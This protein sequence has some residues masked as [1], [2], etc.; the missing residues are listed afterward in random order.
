[1]ETMSPYMQLWLI[2]SILLY[3]V[4]SQRIAVIGG[5]ISGTFVTRYLTE[6]DTGCAFESITLFDPLPLGEVVTENSSGKDDSWQ[7]SR[8]STLQFND[9]R[10]IELGASIMTDKFVLIKEMAA[11]GNLTLQ[12]PF[13]TGLDEPG[14]RDGMLIYNGKGDFALNNANT[15]S[16]SQMISLFWRYNLDLFRLNRAMK[17]AMAKFSDLEALIASPRH[18]FRS[19]SE[20]WGAVTLDSLVRT[21]L[22]E[23]CRRLWISDD[24]PFWRRAIYGQGSLQRELLSATNLVN[25]NQD[26]SQVNALTGLA[27][28]SVVSAETFSIAGGNVKLISTAWDQ[29]LQRRRNQCPGGDDSIRHDFRAISTV[30]GSLEGFEFYGED[31]SSIGD[32]DI[33]ILAAPIS[34]ARIN[35]L[36]KSHVDAS[37][38]QQMPLSGLIENQED[39]TTPFGHEGHSPLPHALPAAIT[40]T[41]T[42]VVTTIVTNATLQ[43]DHFGIDL[44]HIPRGIYMTPMGKAAEHNVTSISQ[45]SAKKGMFKVFSTQYLSRKVLESFFGPNVVRSHEKRWGGRHGG[46]TPDYQGGGESTSFLLFDG[47]TGF[48]GHTRYGTLYYPIALEHTLAC[49]ESSAMGAKVVAKLIAKR[50]GWIGSVPTEVGMGD[51]L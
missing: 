19:P 36:V 27:S 51:E 33:V 9:G 21:S 41:Y 20:M 5:G 16:F 2:V 25:Y 29:A 7:G 12:P 18:F 44:D 32:F 3:P 14:L 40:R 11:A 8:V 28:F 49:I 43:L 31:S 46:A 15:T 10:I 42:A 50:L 26:C 35:F 22:A 6:F 34:M 13:A 47:A 23:Y 1:M 17:D 24:L 39:S 37:V 45:I 4:K 38:L 48:H 30:I